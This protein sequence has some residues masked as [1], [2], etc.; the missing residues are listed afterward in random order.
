MTSILTNNGA[1]VALQTLKSIN[2]DMSKVQSEISTGL[3]VASAKDNSSSWAIASTMKS[4]VG[5]LKTL[6]DSLTSASAMVGVAR[7]A[8]EQTADL[9]R[10]VQE[11]V[12]QGQNPDADTTKLKAEI[13]AL[14]DTITSIAKSAQF[15]GINLV[16]NAGG[17]QTVTV[18]VTRDAAGTVASETF[19][20]GDTDLEAVAT[21]VKAVTFTAGGLDVID[22]QLDLVNTAASGFGA[23][24]ARIDAQNDFLG[25]QAASLQEGVGALVDANMEEASARLQALQ[26]QQQLGTQALS[27]ANQAPQSVLS[28]FK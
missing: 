1:M 6:S 12:V 8:T 16:D 23:A 27:I 2:N 17:A 15:N 4:D 28:L 13:D 9:L 21:A 5:S 26:V 11:K 19:S 18:S 22:A 3:R 20:T 14:A 24:Q 7:S 10:Q 25:K